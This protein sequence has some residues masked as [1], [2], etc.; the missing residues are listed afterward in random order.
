MAG[1]TFP[2]S[3]LNIKVFKCSQIRYI[4]HYLKLLKF[5]LSHSK[6]D[7]DA[8]INHLDCTLNEPA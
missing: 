3:K 8:C 4:N 7:F 2:I 5:Q 6:L 1:Y